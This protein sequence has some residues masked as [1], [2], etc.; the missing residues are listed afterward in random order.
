[1][2][3]WMT[4]FALMFSLALLSTLAWDPSGSLLSLK[5]ATAMSGML[6]LASVITRLARGRI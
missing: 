1:M 4:N 6:L 5:L 2:L 3:G